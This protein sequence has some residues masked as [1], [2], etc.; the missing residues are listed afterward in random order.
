MIFSSVS[1]CPGKSS[2]YLVQSKVRR[3]RRG[4]NRQKDKEGEQKEDWNNGES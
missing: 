1:F 4:E 3:E 2:H